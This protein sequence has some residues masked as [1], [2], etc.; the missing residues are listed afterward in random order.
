MTTELTYDALYSIAQEVDI[1]GRTEM[2]KAEI[3]EALEAEA[4]HLLDP[5][6]AA[7]EVAPGDQV[8]MNHLSSTLTVTEVRDYRGDD[9]TQILADEVHDH[10]GEATEVTDHVVVIMET[11][12]GGRHA[13]V[14]EKAEENGP[15]PWKND[16]EAHLRRWRA[17]DEEW[18]N[19]STDPVFI[20]QIDEEE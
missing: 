15:T 18:M 4:P 3:I 12:R 11:S 17:G 6:G 9:I 20:R 14:T 10:E 2:N 16:T 8:S 7:T 1:D 19:N 5:L 13:L